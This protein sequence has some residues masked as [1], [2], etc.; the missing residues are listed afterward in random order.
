MGRLTDPVA[1]LAA[2]QGLPGAHDWAEGRVTGGPGAQAG[3]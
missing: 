3:D 2:M 1:S